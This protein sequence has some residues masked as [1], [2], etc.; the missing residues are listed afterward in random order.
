MIPNSLLLVE[1][2]E[3]D[4]YLSMR[5]LRKVGFG[6]ITV[7][8]DGSEAVDLLL[9]HDQPLPE[10]LLLDLRLPKLDG[11]EV[12]ARIRSN[13]RTRSLPVLVLTSSEDPSDRDTCHRLGAFSILRKPLQMSELE[14]ALALLDARG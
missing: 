14:Q 8:R 4:E 10:L 5:L 7:A 2:N 6:A 9:D 11:L 12:L 3:D 13:E 1:D